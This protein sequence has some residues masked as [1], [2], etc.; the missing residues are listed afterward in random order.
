MSSSPLNPPLAQ[1]PIFMPSPPPSYHHAQLP[2]PSL[3]P[4]PVPSPLPI[5]MP[6]SPF[7]HAQFLNPFLSQCPVSPPT[8]P[9]SCSANLRVLLPSWFLEGPLPNSKAWHSND[10]TRPCSDRKPREPTQSMPGLQLTECLLCMKKNYKPIALKHTCMNCSH[11][12]SKYF[13]V[14][15]SKLTLLD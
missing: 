14:I 8:T 13:N 2:H 5:S 11:H 12:I 15:G 4:C 3:S 1:S 9:S 10:K 7:L 6:C